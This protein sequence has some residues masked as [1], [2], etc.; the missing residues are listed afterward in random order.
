M[1]KTLGNRG[2]QCST[3]LDS[4][5]IRSMVVSTQRIAQDLRRKFIRKFTGLSFQKV[6]NSHA[7]GW[8]DCR[9]RAKTE[10]LRRQRAR[11]RTPL[12]RFYSKALLLSK[13][14]RAPRY[15]ECISVLRTA[16][17]S[18]G[19]PSTSAVSGTLRAFGGFARVRVCAHQWRRVG[20][21][22]LR[23]RVQGSRFGIKGSVVQGSSP[24]QQV[25]PR[26]HPLTTPGRG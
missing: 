20:I 5:W 25:P 12:R 13:R 6:K 10:G 14:R 23:S 1:L 2:T 18:G 19:R 9:L 22:G 7:A 26:P 16:N 15:H 3:T 11:A 4:K 24:R 17:T 8:V 21:Y